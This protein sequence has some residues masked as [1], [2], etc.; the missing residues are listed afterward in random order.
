MISKQKL[1]KKAELTT[2]TMVLI[3]LALIFLIIVAFVMT[4][5][6]KIFSSTL[7]SCETKSGVCTSTDQCST[8][9]GTETGFDCKDT[10]QICCMNTC[11]GAKG[12]CISGTSCT[13]G[14]QLYTAAC[15]SG[16]VCCK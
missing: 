12:T 11:S 14:E 2:E 16:Q 7:G 1:C 6:I 5:K 13:S 9:G 10:T 3:A 4:G 8:L 15:A